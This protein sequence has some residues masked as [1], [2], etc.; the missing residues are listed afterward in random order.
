LV[1]TLGGQWFGTYKMAS[2]APL[3]AVFPSFD[4]DLASA[5]TQ[6]TN[7]FL[8]DFFLGDLSFLDAMDAPWTYANARLA[9]HY[10]L[11][12]VSG[13]AFQKV[14][15]TGS[16]RAG[17]L[18][19]AAVLTTTSFATRTSVVKRGQ[20]V[21]SNVLCTPPPPPPDNVPALE[22]TTVPAGSSLRTQ[23]EAHIADPNCAGCH[24]SMDPIGF[25]LEHFDGIG[26]WRDKDGTAT[27]DAT[28]QM[29]DG[30]TFDGAL[31]LGS[32]IKKKASSISNC[33]T[34]KL[35]AYSLGRDPVASDQC[36]LDQLKTSFAGANY[37]IRSLVMQM[38]A[39]DT[40]RMRRPVAVGGM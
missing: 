33:A 6:E 28:G 39:S 3:T 40:F 19:Q 1:N 35:F 2:V 34:R 4:A 10:G 14:S 23:L 30:T 29:P 22:K 31:Q 24:T 27:I 12:G 20:W 25:A 13:T 26:A 37:N 21:L 7:L 32:A 38:I 17:L 8:K 16:Q 15:L 11:S 9:K 18:T 5:M 36:Q